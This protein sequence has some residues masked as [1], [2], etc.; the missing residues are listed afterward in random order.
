MSCRRSTG[1]YSRGAFARYRQDRHCRRDTGQKGKLDEFIL[2]YLKSEAAKLIKA[3]SQADLLTNSRTF[4]EGVTLPW[5]QAPR[6]DCYSGY[7]S[8]AVDA[9]GWVSPCDGLHGEENLRQKPLEKIWQSP[10]FQRLRSRVHNCDNPCWDTTH[11]ELN[12]R[13]SGKYW[14]KEFRQIF[15]EMVFYL[16]PSAQRRSPL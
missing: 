8:C 10:S 4:L 5:A 9:F 13:C 1:S 15:K 11:T 7:I 2:A 6:L 14:I 3:A 16:Y 12:I